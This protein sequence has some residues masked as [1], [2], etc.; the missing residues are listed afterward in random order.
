[1][2]LILELA[3]NCPSCVTTVLKFGFFE[4]SALESQ[5]EN[6]SPPYIMGFVK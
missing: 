3:A 1:M 2:S 4:L 6:P 5:R